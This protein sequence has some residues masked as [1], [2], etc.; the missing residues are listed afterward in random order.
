MEPKGSR[1]NPYTWSEYTSKLQNRN[2]QGGWVLNGDNLIYYTHQSETYA[3][4]G[5]KNNPVPEHI[6][7]EMQE[8]EIWT[9]GWVGF[10]PQVIYYNAYGTQFGSYYGT[11]SDPWPMS[12]YDEMFSNGIWESGWIIDSYGST[13]YIQHIPV[14]LTIGN[15][16]GCG[17]GSG[18][19]SGSESGSGSGSG[20][21][22]SGSPTDLGHIRKGDYDFGQL[23]VNDHIFIG[24]ATLHWTDGNTVGTDELSSV[25]LSITMTNSEYYLKDNHI[26]CRW[27]EKY[28]VEFDGN[29]ILEYN[30]VEYVCNTCGTYSIPPSYYL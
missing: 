4:R 16:C 22:G 6:Y 28:E 27:K 15:G 24:R 9:G 30:Q 23:I 21:Y 13:R 1:K 5:K 18:F 20:S 14:A 3:G 29:F 2:W 12:I 17:C 7:E 10:S 19:G 25:N 8:K 11:E 26:Q